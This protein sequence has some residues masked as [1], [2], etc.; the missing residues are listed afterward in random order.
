M[1]EGAAAA[2]RRSRRRRA[3]AVLPRVGG[4][5]PRRGGASLSLFLRDSSS[6]LRALGLVGWCARALLMLRPQDLV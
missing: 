1:P 2:V 3:P 6:S 5:V 4:A